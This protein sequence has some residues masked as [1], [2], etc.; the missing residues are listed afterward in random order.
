MNL[1][2]GA[3]SDTYPNNLIINVHGLK[4]IVSC[5]QLNLFNSR[6]ISLLPTKLEI[7]KLKEIADECNLSFTVHLPPD[8]DI[9]STNIVERNESLKRII[10]IYN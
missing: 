4:N 9:C 1:K 3:T 2:I 5:V 10:P 8:I 7:Q 6:D